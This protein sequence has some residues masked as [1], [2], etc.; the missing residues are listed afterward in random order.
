MELNIDPSLVE[1]F[2]GLKILVGR[3]E[4]VTVKS[5]VPELEAFKEEVTQEIR[6]SYDLETV[7]DDQTFRAYRDFFW[8]IKVDP[9]KTRPAAEALIRRVLRGRPLPRINSLVDA[10]NLASMKS[11]VAFAAFDSDELGGSLLMR[12]AVEGEDFLGIGMAKPLR[13]TGTEVVIADGERLVAIYPYRDAE[14]CKI[15]EGTRN[16]LLVAC[17]VPGISEDQLRLAMD[18]SFEL[19]T[20]FCG[21]TSRLI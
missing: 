20:R 6:G 11:E 14:E 9:T 5:R 17:G 10:Y 4:N 19:V 3:V 13:L 8:R 7:K 12:F 18:L 21:G 2:P 1:F 15:T 16:V